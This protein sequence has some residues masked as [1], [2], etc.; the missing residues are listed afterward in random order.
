MDIYFSLITGM[1][2]A[3]KGEFPDGGWS[4]WIERGVEE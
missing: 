2:E 4:Q 1:E 3:L